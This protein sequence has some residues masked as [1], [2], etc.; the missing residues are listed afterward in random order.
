MSVA[1]ILVAMPDTNKPRLY[2]TFEQ[3]MKAKRITRTGKPRTA[4]VRYHAK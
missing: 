3:L 1:E 2:R 4:E